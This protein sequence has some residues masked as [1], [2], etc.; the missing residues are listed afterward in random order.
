MIV[1]AVSAVVLFAAPVQFASGDTVKV[2]YEDDPSIQV[3]FPNGY[4]I[5]R[6]SDLI[7]VASSDIYDMGK[8]GMMFFTCNPDGSPIRT[9]SETPPYTSDLNGNIMTY[10]FSNLATDIEMSFSDLV[11]LESPL[12]SLDEPAGMIN[13]IFGDDLLTTTAMLASAVVAAVMLIIMA[14]II[15]MLDSIPVEPERS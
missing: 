11:K 10:V 14:M 8:T 15:R 6:G 13:N 1:A 12:D 7:I 2:F 9:T 5:E 3:E 4:M